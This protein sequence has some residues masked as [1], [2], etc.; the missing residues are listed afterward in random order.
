MANDW[1]SLSA[2]RRTVLMGGAATAASLMVPAGVAQA[3]TE[4]PREKTMVLIG[5]NARDGRWVDYE[6]W[7]PYSVGSNHQNGINLIYEPLA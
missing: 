7:N 1:R 4:I 6:L 5:I 2:D 3:E